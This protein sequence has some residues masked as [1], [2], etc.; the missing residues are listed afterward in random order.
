MYKIDQ[1]VQKLLFKLEKLEINVKFW[2]EDSNEIC[3]IR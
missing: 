2:K 1:Y 3:I